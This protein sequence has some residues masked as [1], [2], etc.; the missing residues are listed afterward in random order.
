MINNPRDTPFFSL[1]G[2]EYEELVMFFDP[3]RTKTKDILGPT[4]YQEQA[5]LD[6]QEE[7]P[8]SNDVEFEN[9]FTVFNV[10]QSLDLKPLNLGMAFY[11]QFHFLFLRGL[12]LQEKIHRRITPKVLFLSLNT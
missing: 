5:F 11:S 1:H 9:F 4:I 3:R 10:D 12:G 2:N 7:I 6:V 8:A